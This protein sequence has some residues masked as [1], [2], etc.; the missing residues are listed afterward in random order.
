[1]NTPKTAVLATAA[2]LA[3]G[4]SGNVRPHSPEASKPQVIISASPQIILWPQGYVKFTAR[5]VNS[6]PLQCFRYGWVYGDG[7][8][9]TW[10]ADTPELF[11]SSQVI[12]LYG[13][14]VYNPRFVVECTTGLYYGDVRAAVQ[15]GQV[16]N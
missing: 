15:V 1:M 5:I 14:G 13:T 4:C 9:K 3:I 11:T 12:H 8:I 2:L 10:E 6:H 16:G 7:T